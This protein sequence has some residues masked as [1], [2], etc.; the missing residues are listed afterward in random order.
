MWICK[1]CKTSN[2]NSSKK[3]HGENCKALRDNE[4]IELPVQL[5]KH[6]DTKK[7]Y[8]YC[9]KCWKDTWWLKTS[10]KGKKAWKCIECNSKAFLI[11][12]PK[13]FPEVVPT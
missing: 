10:Y 5:T 12:K 3:C 7:V 9:P 2:N 11:G 13:P 8:D 1:Q 6:K 4:A